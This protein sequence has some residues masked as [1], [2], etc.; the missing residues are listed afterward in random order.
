MREKDPLRYSNLIENLSHFSGEILLSEIVDTC[1]ELASSVKSLSYISSNSLSSS[2][3]SAKK[4]K[5]ITSTPSSAPKSNLANSDKVLQSEPKVKLRTLH[6]SSSTITHSPVLEIDLSQSDHHNPPTMATS[7]PDAEISTQNFLS[8]TSDIEGAIK[9]MSPIPM[10]ELEDEEDLEVLYSRLK[11]KQDVPPS[12]RVP[13]EVFSH[14]AADPGSLH[15]QVDKIRGFLSS[16]TPNVGKALLLLDQ[17][18]ADILA[19]E[20]INIKPQPQRENRQTKNQVPSCTSQVSIPPPPSSPV[21][22]S[23]NLTILLFPNSSSSKN[24]TELLNEELLP[25]DFNN[26]N[27]KSIKDNGLAISFKSTNDMVNL[28]SKIDANENL[29][30]LIK[31]KRPAKCLPS[32]TL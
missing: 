7:F 12:Q 5:L 24:L 19:T 4:P 13:T 25:K 14:S 10:Q 30:P 11:D 26:T 18:Q 23:L 21:E 32:L 31:S 22:P 6:S 3:T 27:I 17:L 1:E 20:L 15:D 28:Q 9:E 29:K 16:T 2:P 8:D